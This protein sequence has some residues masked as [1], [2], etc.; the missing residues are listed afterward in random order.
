MGQLKTRSRSR[1]ITAGEAIK[2][3]S[4]D[5]SIGSVNP[6]RDS[7]SELI[8]IGSLATHYVHLLSHLF[9]PGHLGPLPFQP[10]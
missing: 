2:L 5:H 6:V 4:S 3:E 9:I 8:E 10:L 1:G 7:Q